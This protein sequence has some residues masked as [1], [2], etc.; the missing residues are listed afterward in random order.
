MAEDGMRE[1][2]TTEAPERPDADEAA[3]WVGYR[4]DDLAGRQVGKVE[5]IYADESSQAPEW[6]LV[7]I[8]RVGSRYLVPARDAVA[9]IKRVWVPYTRDAIRLAPKAKPGEALTRA[10]EQELLDHYGVGTDAGRAAEIGSLDAD[11]TT[12]RSL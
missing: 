10:A 5:A 6:L 7:R 4:L 9:G 3:G 8:G 11:A 1:S 12:A 2:S